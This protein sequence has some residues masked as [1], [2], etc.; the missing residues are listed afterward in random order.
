M[1]YSHI[2]KGFQ[3]KDEVV[4][5]QNANTVPPYALSRIHLKQS[6]LNNHWKN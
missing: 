1:K 5:G 4:W 6:P 2:S 3:F